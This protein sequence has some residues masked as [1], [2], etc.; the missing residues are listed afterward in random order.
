MNMA[1]LKEYPFVPNMDDCRMTVTAEGAVCYIMD[2]CCRNFTAADKEAVDR[3]IV[4]LAIQSA[5][6]REARGCETV[7]S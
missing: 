3:K 1:R 4:Q 7:T 2:T 6:K 5:L